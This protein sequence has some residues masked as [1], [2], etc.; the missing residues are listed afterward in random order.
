MRLDLGPFKSAKT[1]LTPSNVHKCPHPSGNS[2]RARKNKF[3]G[4]VDVWR[5]AP[6]ARS[7]S[8]P[9]RS[10]EP[11]TASRLCRVTIADADRSEA[12]SCR[13]GDPASGQRERCPRWCTRR[14]AAWR[15]GRRFPLVPPRRAATGCAGPPLRSGPP[16]AA[17]RSKRDCRSAPA[18][19]PAIPA[20]CG[21]KEGKNGTTD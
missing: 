19:H 1:V 3:R 10:T 5:L 16:G 17:R 18:A 9:L 21:V 6:V 15:S 4:E 12:R 7:R 8:I 14:S 13:V 20:G 11:R 2:Q